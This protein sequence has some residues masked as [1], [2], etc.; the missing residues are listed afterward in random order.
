MAKK[1]DMYAKQYDRYI[2][3]IESALSEM[4][5]DINIDKEDRVLE[6]ALYSL[7]A[8][9]KRIRP[10]MMLAAADMFDI[11]GDTVLK[12]ACAIE[13]IHTYSLIHDDLPCMD[14]D[15]MRRG[16]PTCH[17]AFGEGYPGTVKGGEK[18]TAEELAAKGVNQSVI[19]EDV[20]IGSADMNI[21]GLCENG[22]TVQIFEN[23]EWVF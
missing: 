14:D 16:R 19:H 23:G 20:M 3:R 11:S 12:M 10:V 13:M 22:Q 15:E 8:G 21:T 2:D 1:T 7:M 18:M 5:S 9:G 4:F 17:I 6:A